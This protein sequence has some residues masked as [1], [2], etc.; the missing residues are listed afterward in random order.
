MPCRTR[1]ELA[2]SSPGSRL[3]GRGHG[4]RQPA[5]PARQLRGPAPRCRPCCRR[6]RGRPPP[7]PDSPAPSSD[8]RLAGSTSASS[9]AGHHHTRPTARPADRAPAAAGRPYARRS[10]GR[11]AATARRR[12]IRRRSTR[13]RSRAAVCPTAT[14]AA[15]AH[16]LWW[17]GEDR[18]HGLRNRPAGGR[19]RGTATAARRRS[20]ALLRPRRHALGPAYAGRHHRA[21][22]GRRPRRRRARPR[23]PDRRLQHRHP[24]TPCPPCAPSWNPDLPVIGT[25]PAIKPA[26]A[27][28]GPVAIW[29]TP[30]TTGS[31]YQRGL[32]E[33]VRRRRRGHRGALPRPR[34]RGGARR[35]GRHRRRRRRRRRPAPPRT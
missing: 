31:P 18:A 17:P 26:A 16:R 5:V 21:R 7:G 13:W 33:R 25:V 1:P 35:R 8:G 4:Q 28:G 10:P 30:A 9:R 19:R 29:A 34:R 6:R 20:R 15:R 2:R 23:R 12:G 27:G 11:A 22:A 24:C 14:G 32:I 3:A